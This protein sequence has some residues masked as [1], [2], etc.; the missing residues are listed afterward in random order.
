[1]DIIADGGEEIVVIYT[2]GEEKNYFLLN[3][4]D[5]EKTPRPTPCK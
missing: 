2:E 5:S 1:L 3:F 4:I